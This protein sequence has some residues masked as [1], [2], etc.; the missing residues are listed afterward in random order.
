MGA[1]KANHRAQA[2][3]KPSRQQD[4]LRARADEAD[5]RLHGKRFQD[6]RIMSWLLLAL[7]Q[8]AILTVLLLVSAALLRRA[9][10]PP[11][12]SRMS[13]AKPALDVPAAPDHGPSDDLLDRKSVV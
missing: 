2:I 3:L 8:L 5:W 7:T 1:A 13:G 11:R 6:A 4:P 9:Y 12:P 10:K